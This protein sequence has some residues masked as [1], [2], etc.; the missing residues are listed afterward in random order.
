MLTYIVFQKNQINKILISFPLYVLVHFLPF[1]SFFLPSLPSLPPPSLS[2]SLPSSLS[3]FSD[4]ISHCRPSLPWFRTNL[5][6][7]F[8]IGI[9]GL[10]YHTQV[11]GRMCSCAY[12]YACVCLC[13]HMFTSVCKPKSNVGS[14]L[15]GFITWPTAH[16]FSKTVWP[17]SSRMFHGSDCHY[18]KSNVPLAFQW[19]LGLRTHVL[20]LV[21]YFTK[22]PSSQSPLHPSCHST[23]SFSIIFLK[24]DQRKTPWRK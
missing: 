15:T 7:H 11:Y 20:L 9:V 18:L 23:P 1:P 2:P 5:I 22:C 19:I 8:P 4:M 14:I 3:I 17:P 10:T 12:A 6:P 21:Q 16:W 13:T 24:R